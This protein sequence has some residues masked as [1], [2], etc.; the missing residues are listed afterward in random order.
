MTVKNSREYKYYIRALEKHD[1]ET[2]QKYLV[3]ISKLLRSENSLSKIIQELQKDRGLLKKIARN[4]Y[5][6]ENGFTKLSLAKSDDYKLRVH[7]WKDYHYDTNIHNHRFNCHSYLINGKI[8]NEIYEYGNGKKSFLANTFIYWPRQNKEEYN[9]EFQKPTRLIKKDEFTHIKGEIYNLDKTILHKTKVVDKDTITI[10]VED[11]RKLM[12][13][14][15]VF[16]TSLSKSQTIG[17]FSLSTENI[18]DNLNKL[19]NYAR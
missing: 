17:S 11:R 7:F 8:Q 4:S 1:G 9:L 19:R 2:H 14:A 13:H 18:L 5:K 12:P 6:H 10:F 15:K 16:S 3:R